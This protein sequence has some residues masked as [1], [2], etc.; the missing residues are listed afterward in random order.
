[1]ISI[2]AGLILCLGG[3]LIPL[4]KGNAQRVYALALPIVSFCNLVGV[5]FS[6]LDIGSYHQIEVM[7]LTLTMSRVDKLSLLFG[8]IFHIAALLSVIYSL[9]IDDAKQMASGVIY[10]GAGVGAVFAGDLITLFVFWEVTAFASVFLI[11]AAK[12]EA[13]N[14]V[15]IRYLVIQVASGVLLLAGAVMH[16][17]ANGTL[18][19]TSMMEWID[20]PGTRLILLAFG[21]KCAFPFLHNW[22]Q[23][24]YPK[25]TPT[26]AVFLSAFTT[27][28]AVY[29]LIRGFPGYEPLIYV[30][31]VMTLFP[32]FFAV[33]ENDLRKVLAYSLNNQ[34]GFMVVA[35]GVGSELAL[36]GACAHA[37][38]HI[39]YKGLLFMSMGAVLHRVG[40]TK[41]S[42]LGGLYRSMPVT[43]VCCIIGAASI[44]AFPLTSGFISKALTLSAVVDAGYSWVWVGLLVASAGVMEHSGIKIPYFA[45]F[46]HD[47]GIRCERAPL[48]MQVAMIITAALCLAIGCF[49]GYL[50][51]L[52][53]FAVDYQPYTGAHVVTQ[54]QLLLFAMLAFVI[55]MKYW[56]YPEEEEAENLDTDWFYRRAFPAL[57][58]RGVIAINSLR[59]VVLGIAL[60]RLSYFLGRVQ[61][62]HGPG[63]IMA[64]TWTSS[65]MVFLGK[66]SL[67]FYLLLYLLT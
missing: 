21:I 35:V 6:G 11:W 20:A 53:P 60:G 34:L 62:H 5:G 63:G 49:P 37:F 44:S 32:L 9:H 23:D 66:L 59:V 56:G 42:Q 25:A 39:L 46:G 31:V 30:G 12:N 40:T 41:A 65:R 36:N 4:L 15:A 7:G 55:L 52:L 8:Y 57:W 18:A 58:R 26:G 64:A 14:R 43:A 45:F 61:K 29:T 10:A 50:Y 22:L 47:S 17:Q 1:M 2:P 13:A 38:A 19:F 67:A 16:Y 51:D 28:L 33:I 54:F 3:L 24:A 27:K 48:N